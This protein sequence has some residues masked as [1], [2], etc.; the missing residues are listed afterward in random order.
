MGQ[1]RNQ[2]HDLVFFPDGTFL[3]KPRVVQNLKEFCDHFGFPRFMEF[4][5]L[6]IVNVPA[7]KIFQNAF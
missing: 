3:L 1:V 5:L 4:K 2:L 7:L 6:H